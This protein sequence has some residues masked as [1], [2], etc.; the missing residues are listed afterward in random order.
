[1]LSTG[2]NPG[3]L[4]DAWP[5]FMTGVCKEVKMVKTTRIQDATSRRLPFQK[6]I[7]AGCTVEEFQRRVDARTL[8]H[9]GLTESIA[10]IGDTLGWKLD[11]I[12]ESIEPIIAQAVVKSPYL[13]VEPGQVAGVRQI[14]YG[15]EKTIVRVVAEFQASIGAGEPYDEVY[16]NG[17]PELRVRVL[18][19]THGDVG[20]VAMVVNSIGR[21]VEAPP[22]LLTMRDIPMV[23]CAAGG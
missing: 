8:R 18:G 10:M 22:G 1:V 2:I 23:V 16:I 11:K 7:G 3:F 9:V 20:T 5:L 17:V 14:G 19:G 21:V 15:F 13:S 12:T 4:M 6:K